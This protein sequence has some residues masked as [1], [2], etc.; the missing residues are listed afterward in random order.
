MIG[1]GVN[2]VEEEGTQTRSDNHA[3]IVEWVKNLTSTVLRVFLA[4]QEKCQDEVKCVIIVTWGLNPM[5]IEIRVKCVIWECILISTPTSHVF[6]VPGGNRVITCE[7]TA[8][9]VPTGCIMTESG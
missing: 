1:V 2:N 7:V 4:V 6:L 9:N 5:K 3:R 8:T